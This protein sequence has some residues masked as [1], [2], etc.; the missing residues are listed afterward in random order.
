MPKTRIGKISFWVAVGAFISLYVNILNIF[1]LSS[2]ML[3]C[4][5][6]SIIAM[7]KYRDRAILLFVSALLG[8][9]G[10]IFVLGV[11]FL[12]IL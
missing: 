6:T 12:P 4:G 3:V 5:V 10:L 1:L 8:L 11:L 9:A 7:T 2:V